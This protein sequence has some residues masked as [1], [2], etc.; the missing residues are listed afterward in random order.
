MLSERREDQLTARGNRQAGKRRRPADRPHTTTTTTEPASPKAKPKDEGDEAE[1][2]DR[3]KQ[4]AKREREGGRTGGGRKEKGRK[5]ERGAR[6][7]DEE[8]TEKTTT[9][10]NRARHARRDNKQPQEHE[11]ERQE[12]KLVPTTTQR[13]NSLCAQDRDG[14]VVVRYRSVNRAAPKLVVK[15]AT[16]ASLQNAPN[17]PKPARDRSG[18]GG[19]ENPSTRAHRQSG[20]HLD[21]WHSPVV[22][23]VG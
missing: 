18:E 13:S 23:S 6:E 7:A 2:T 10:R 14:R 12:D 9:R 15:P 1:A 3:G 20:A 17:T 16:R 11:Q 21:K 4:D 19:P 5:G 8:R 22:Y